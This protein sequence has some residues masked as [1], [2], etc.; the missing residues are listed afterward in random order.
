MYTSATLSLAALEYFVNV[1]A[2]EAPTNLVAISADIPEH[3]PLAEV[4][5][6]NLPANWRTY[7][8]PES[9]ADRGT[10]WVRDGQTAVI[11]VPSAIIPKERNYL[12][13]PG[14]P[15]VKAIR[16]GSAEPFSFDPRMW[17]ER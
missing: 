9:L 7:P 11:A 16:V 10:K 2:T 1:E 4:H 6:M 17:R 13:N 15:D 8:P 14:H 3:L 5:M 12:I